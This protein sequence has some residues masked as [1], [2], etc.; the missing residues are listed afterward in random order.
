MT[1]SEHE[2]DLLLGTLD[3]LVLKTLSWGP[4]HG[5]G[6]ARWIRESSDGTF[7]ILDGALYAALHRL[8]EREWVQ[9]EWGHTDE[10]KRAKFYRLTAAGRRRLRQETRNWERYAAGIARVLSTAPKPAG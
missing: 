5:Y 6:V 2:L 1:A 4:M 3:I 8:E 7:R 9:S 10:G